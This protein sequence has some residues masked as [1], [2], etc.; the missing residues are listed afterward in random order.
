MFGVATR[1]LARR[2]TRPLRSY[3]Q[4]TTS[5]ARLHSEPKAV[6]LSQLKDSFLDATSSTYL[7]QLEAQYNKD[8]SSVDHSWAAFF[9]SLGT[10]PWP[11][12][13]DL[14]PSPA[15]VPFTNGLVDGTEGVTLR[16]P[17]NRSGA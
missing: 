11:R 4:L 1:V 7:E 14:G 9:R 16:R 3:R 8:P 10:R 12:P 15:R 5:V 6:P 2:A 17:R 13:R